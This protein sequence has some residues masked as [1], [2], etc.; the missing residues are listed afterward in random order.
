MD[1]GKRSV[2][3][4]TWE[5]QD[6]SYQG[7]MLNSK[8]PL[9][10]EEDTSEILS[11]LPTLQGLDVVEL[12]SGIGRFTGSLAKTADHVLAV[13]FVDKFI[14]K[15]KEVNSMFTNIDYIV[16]DAMNIKLEP[17][18]VGF[19]FTNWLFMYLDDNDTTRLLNNILK[20]VPSEGYVFIRESCLYGS[21]DLSFGE[22]TT[23]YREA[24]QYEELF[25][26][27]STTTSG[28]AKEYCF[29]IDKSKSLDS[30]IKVMKNKN[31]IA[32]LLQKV[33]RENEARL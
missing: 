15:N 16:D 1:N 2:L 7:M 17:N 9:L 29:R 21:G 12:G 8:A 24:R 4:K 6:A 26:T 18:S 27:I 11:Y 3:R 31:Q 32:W 10:H 23:Y 22:N 25:R 28:G 33:R 14:K 13:D 30:Y 5:Q 20:W 19:V